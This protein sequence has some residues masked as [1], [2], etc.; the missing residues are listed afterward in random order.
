MSSIMPSTTAARFREP[1]SWLERVTPVLIR[2][3]LWPARVMRAR[4]AL[5][6]LAGLSDHELRDIGLTRQYLRDA[7]AFARDED[8]TRHLACVVAQRGRRRRV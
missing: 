2:L 8:P 1:R 7:S 6:Q 5:A 4:A 3:L